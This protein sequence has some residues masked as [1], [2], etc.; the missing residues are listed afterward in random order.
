MALED[1]FLAEDRPEPKKPRKRKPGIVAIPEDNGTSSIEGLQKDLL[2]L[3]L[4]AITN[5]AETARGNTKFAAGFFLAALV[6]IGIPGF[7]RMGL[8][9]MGVTYYAYYKA[10]KK[11]KEHQK[12]AEDIR[13]RLAALL[14]KN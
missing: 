3:D 12:S 6:S 5:Q 11:Q 8:V 10:D 1:Q 14:S 9:L 4:Q 2:L 7:F 13:L